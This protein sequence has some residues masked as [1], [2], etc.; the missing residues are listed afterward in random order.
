[1]KIKN[2]TL[3]LEQRALR[4]DVVKAFLRYLEFEVEMTPVL[5]AKHGLDRLLALP[6]RP[7]L[8][9]Y[10]P[11]DIAA[12]CRALL[13]KFEEENWG[14]DEAGEQPPPSEDEEPADIPSPR[15][16]SALR[17]L[18]A[19]NIRLPPPS[20]PIWGNQGIMH[21]VALKQGPK[22][23]YSLDPR[24]LDKKRDAKVFGHNGLE[25][26]AWWPYQKLA[27]YH[28]AHGAPIRGITGTTASGAY[29]IVTSG[30]SGTYDHLDQDFGDKLFY[31]ADNSHDNTNP[32]TVV[33]VSNATK[34]LHKSLE[35][36]K[37]VRVLRSSGGKK[38][39]TPKVG[40]R[41]DGLYRVHLVRRETNSKGGLYEQFELHRLPGQRSLDEI[42]ATVPSREQQDAFNKIKSGY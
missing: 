22:T 11:P 28:G 18:G 12:K 42:Q 8:Q 23:V 37:P 5:K 27:H 41:Y 9:A 2:K 34:S 40:I 38:K 17:N 35:T 15:S 16:P 32:N 26:G 14:A 13:S 39:Y 31:S 6:E 36:G 19:E 20:H 4:V 30:S 24:Y 10:T 7:D 1:M 29:S 33:F 25:P 21:G 3:N